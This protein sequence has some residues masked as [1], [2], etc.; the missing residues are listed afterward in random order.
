MAGSSITKPYTYN[1]RSSHRVSRACNSCRKRKV[2]CNGVQPCSK[3]ITSNLRCHYDGIQVD[4]VKNNLYK[5][6]EDVRKC[7]RPLV[8]SIKNLEKL[9]FANP[10]KVNS[11][12]QTLS[13]SIEDLKHDLR[14]S[15]KEESVSNLQSELSLET[16]L[17][18]GDYV[19]FNSFAAFPINSSNT[20][21]TSLSFWGLYSPIMLLSDQ[22]FRWLFKRLLISP[23][24]DDI[25]VK[26]TI[27]LYLKFMDYATSMYLEATE[28]S[29]SPL[30]WYRKSFD[31][32]STT[33]DVDLIKIILLD[34]CKSTSYGAVGIEI[35]KPDMVMKSINSLYKHLDKMPGVSTSPSKRFQLEPLLFMLFLEVLQKPSYSGIYTVEMLSPQLD[36]LEFYFWSA[37][38]TALN[39]LIGPIVR[40]GIDLGFNRWEFYLNLDENEANER[41]KMWWKC[42]WWD[43][44]GSLLTGKQFQ[45][46]EEQMACLLPKEWIELGVNEKMDPSTFMRCVNFE[47]CSNEVAAEIGHY[48]LAKI[49]QQVYVKIMY[50][51]QLCDYRIFSKE[52]SEMESTVEILFEECAD[53]CQLLDS[54]EE[55]FSQPFSASKNIE[56]YEFYLTYA[57]SKILILTYMENVCVRLSSASNPS[58]KGDIAAYVAELQEKRL[59]TAVRAVQ[60]SF[61]HESPNTYKF[62]QVHL[63]LLIQINI[64][65]INNMEKVGVENYLF[66]ACDIAS[67]YAD[68]LRTIQKPE[69]VKYKHFMKSIENCIYFIFILTRVSFQ[70]LQKSRSISEV[71]VIKMAQEYSTSTGHLCKELLDVSSPCFAELLACPFISSWHKQV[72]DMVREVGGSTFF[73]KLETTGYERKERVIMPEKNSKIHNTLI[74]GFE[75]FENLE[76][77][78]RLDIFPDLYSNFFGTD[79]FHI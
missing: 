41:R 78:L 69:N 42:Y 73:E 65:C 70:I 4:M 67:M 62:L 46:M 20:K 59:D 18:D 11:L 7:L 72:K 44:Y 76:E 49:I 32:G 28:Y 54:M 52:C 34:I 45:I 24:V 43:K 39:R 16:H 21:H 3:C 9:S 77:F 8:Q 40:L 51:A 60:R 47:N 30:L 15:L 22:G 79:D 23:N 55:L 14:L 38:T 53:I 19:L 26:R 71:Q 58:K 37:E 6:E 68:Y 35:K 1:K 29:K 13:T 31:V 64:Y 25:D 57:N 61:S 5:D 66:L 12:I 10:A 63:M 50:N 33:T 2:K 56:D 75:P 36:F 48:L 17:I 27:Y 74:E